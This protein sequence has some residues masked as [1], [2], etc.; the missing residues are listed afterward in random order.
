M[1]YK[2]IEMEN[3]VSSLE[4]L[5]ERR[6]I[7]GYAAAR[8][9]RL[10]K[11]QAQEYFAIRDDLVLKYGKP[12]L[13]ENGNE[14]GQTELKIASPEFDQFLEELKPLMD[15]EHEVDIFKVPVK[16]AIGKLSGTEILELDW[17]LEG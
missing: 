17:M 11:T 13:D 16:E 2:N 5:L 8:N 14:T 9:T 4:P 6:D 3:M 10:L 15:I 12:Q 7:L 1:K